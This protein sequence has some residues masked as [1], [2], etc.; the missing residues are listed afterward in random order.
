MLK[1]IKNELFEM[2]LFS[3]LDEGTKLKVV[4]YNKGIQKNLDLS[5]INYKFFSGRYIIYSSKGFGKEYNGKD[6]YLLYEGEFLNGKR[7]GKGKEYQYDRYIMPTEYDDEKIIFDGEYRNGKRN[8][9]GKKL[10][11]GKIIFEGTYLNGK[12][13]GKGKKYSP[14]GHIIF[15]GEYFNN[16]EWIGSRFDDEGNIIYKLNNDINGKGKEYDNGKL[17]FEGEY[18]NG[19]RHGYG[20]EYSYIGEITFEGEY[21]NDKRNG[22]GKEF[23]DGLKIFEGEYLNDLRWAGN[24]FDDNGN[25]KDKLNNNM[26]G[27]V[28][29]Y[30]NGDYLISVYEY[31]KG[32]RNGKA[33]IF[34]GDYLNG[35]RNGHG[36]EYDNEAHGIIFEGEYLN[37]MRNGKGKEYDKYYDGTGIKLFLTY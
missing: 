18:L 9:Y 32:V 19:K 28:I 11:F 6:D 36:I 30:D 33:I 16:K 27:K 29:E 22:K 26:N 23:W 12:R 7:H 25:I 14:D 8:G 10:F 3:F 2:L 37:G 15:D 13:H 24:W 5:I 17:K 34:E 21:L 4:K 35:K 1:C 20:K 31:V